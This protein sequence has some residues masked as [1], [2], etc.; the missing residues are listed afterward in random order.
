MPVPE[1]VRSIGHRFHQMK[2]SGELEQRLSKLQK[3]QKRATTTN[4]PHPHHQQESYPKQQVQR[5]VFNT[6]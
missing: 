5:Q 2:Q 3:K 4:G 1:E 6:G